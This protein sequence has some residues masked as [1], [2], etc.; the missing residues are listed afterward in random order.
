MTDDLIVLAN[1]VFELQEPPTKDYKSVLDW[2]LKEK[3]LY[4]GSYNF[5]WNRDDLVLIAGGSKGGRR[6]RRQD[7]FER[8]LESWTKFRVLKVSYT[9][10]E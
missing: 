10:F 9:N 7:F 4:R 6:S 1:Q 3:P 5:I 2:I 8:L